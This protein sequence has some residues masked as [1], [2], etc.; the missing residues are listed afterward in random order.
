MLED[1]RTNS[2]LFLIQVEHVQGEIMV[3]G[4]DGD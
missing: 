4:L 2:Q 1:L 3:A